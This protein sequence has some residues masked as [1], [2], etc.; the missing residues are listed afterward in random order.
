MNPGKFQHDCVSVEPTLYPNTES[1]LIKKRGR[2]RAF[3]HSIVWLTTLIHSIT[4]RSIAMIPTQ[5]KADEMKML[6]MLFRTAVVE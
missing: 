6:W 2:A 1:K 4:P 3:T 5:G